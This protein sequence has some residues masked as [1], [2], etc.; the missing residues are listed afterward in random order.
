MMFLK[1]LDLRN[2]LALLV[3]FLFI[4]SI[5]NALKQLLNGELVAILSFAE[6]VDC[7]LTA[8]TNCVVR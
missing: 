8:N 5:F 6:H 4:V 2:I 3:F 7:L 1:R